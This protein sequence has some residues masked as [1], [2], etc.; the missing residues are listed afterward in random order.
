MGKR[1]IALIAAT[2]DGELLEDTI[3]GIKARLNGCGLDLY[4]FLCFPGFGIDSPENF[5]N[6]N[7]FALPDYNDFEGFIFSANVVEGY[8]MIK[9]YH[10]ELLHCGKPM[11]SLDCEMDG[12]ISVLPDGYK[13]QYQM[14]EHLIVEHGCRTLNYVGGST[15]HPDNAIRKK[16]FKDALIA[17]GIP[18]E[19]RRIRDYSFLDSDGH[20]AYAEFKE[21]GIATP[22]AVVCANDAMALGYC[23]AA[24]EDGLYPPEA[25]LITG[26]DHS[27]SSKAFTPMITT[28]DKNGFEMGYSSCD[29]LLRIMAGEKVEDIVNYEQKLVLHGSCGCYAPEELVQ[30]DTRQLQRQIYFRVKEESNYYERLNEIRQFLALSDG[31]GLF[32]Y[33]L[34]DSMR[35]NDI[36]GYCM[37][38]NQEVYYGT[39]PIE[40]KWERGYNDEVYVLS[41]M[42]HNVEQPEAQLIRSKDLVPDYLLQEEEK[43]YEY[44]F[45]PLQ[46][47]G[48]NLGYMCV[49]DGSGMLGRRMLLYTASAIANAYSN[50]RNLENLRKMNKR[51]DSVYVK[52]ALTDM[53]NR[54]GYMR[55]G[56][57]MYEKSKV[58]GKP[59]MVMFMDMDRLKE[60][61]DIYGHSQGDNALILFSGVLK[62]CA[63]DDKIAVRY[64]GDEFLIIGTVDGKEGAEAFKKVLEDELKQVNDNSGLPYLIE[65]SIGYVLTDSKSK[66]EL[67]DYVK[68]ADELMYEVKKRNRKNRKS[69]AEQ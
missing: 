21:L 63:A 28:V 4:V 27:E 7:I 55:D 43:C 60:I 2:W 5:G 67:D 32:N 9:R 44:L 42:K 10:S 64:G 35:K 16:A 18:I 58:Y 48:A 20:K 23:Q 45:V 39:E 25:F 56:Y 50:L 34:L 15:L 11:V 13:A 41:G 38:I 54:F 65:A 36:Y 33:Y 53:Y 3:S 26:Y 51:L 8:E 31:E 29:V 46:K 69:Y 61:N 47:N 59:L 6:F 14:V 24:E 57:T 37:C 40:F 22:D 68:E 30:F 19:E 17:H 1:K 66:L 12:I 52:D 62:K 49:V